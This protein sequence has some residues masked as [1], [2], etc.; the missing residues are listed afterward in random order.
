VEL[1]APRMRRSDWGVILLSVGAI[2]LFNV[3]LTALFPPG[4][5]DAAKALLH[6]ATQ[7]A[8]IGV[9]LAALG[10]IVLTP[11][12]EELGFRGL[13]YNALM[14]RYTPRHALVITAVVFAACHVQYYLSPVRLIEVLALGFVLTYAYMRSNNLATSIAIHAIC[15]GLAFGLTLLSAKT[16]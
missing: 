9:A 13:L 15:N 12:S 1:I 14:R 6:A 2:A 10:L 7:G 4:A 8:P 16:L 3:A 5:H 11:V